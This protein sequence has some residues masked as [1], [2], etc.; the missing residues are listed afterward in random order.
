MDAAARRQ[1]TRRRDEALRRPAGRAAR[2]GACARPASARRRSS[3]ASPTPTRAGRTR[4]SRPSGSASTCASCGKLFDKYG[5]RSALYGHF[6][7]GCIHARLE[8]R[9]RHAPT[10][11]RRTARFLDEAADLV[12]VA[13]RLALRRARRRPVARRAAAEDVRR[14]AGRG[15]P[16]VQVD[17]GPGLEDEPRQGRRPGPR[18]PRTS[19]SAPTTTRRRSKTHFAYPRRRR[20]LRARDRCAAS[21]S[22]SAG[23]PSGGVMCPSYMVTREEKHS[24]R[25]RARLLWEMLNGE[26]ARAAGATRRSTRRSTSASRARAARATARSTST[27]RRYKAEFLSHYYERPAAAAARLRVRADRPGGAARVAGAGARQFRDARRRASRALAKRPRASRRSARSRAS[28]RRRFRTGSR[29]RPR[30]TPA[31]RSVILWPDTF[32]N[33]FHARSA[34]PRSRCSRTRASASTIPR[35]TSAAAGRS[36]TTGCSTSRGATSSACSTRCATTSAPATPVV[37]IEPS[38]VAVFKDELPKLMPERRGRTRLAQQTFHL[39]RVP[40]AASRLRAAAARAARRS[41]TATAT[42]SATGG[43]RAENAA[44]RGDGPRRRGARRRLLRH[45]RPLGFERDHYDVSIACGE[46]VL[47]PGGARGRPS[48]TLVVADGFSCRDADRADAHRPRALH[49]AEVLK[50]A[51]ERDEL[52]LYPEHA[53]EL[54]PAPSSHGLPKK[55]LL[56][57]GAVALATGAALAARA[58]RT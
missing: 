33:H 32:N 51:R 5:Y 19:G 21:A 7:Q 56:A 38:C 2:L 26:R 12:L 41:S 25:G 13:R 46:R 52:P 30:G 36:T 14:R 42:T 39:E 10:A 16:R 31:G 44:A 40:P 45:G 49:V 15:V 54:Q 35:A 55:S 24:T 34:S 27:C 58:N 53:P 4:P 47:L 50:L 48:D 17:L 3:P 29:A 1:A 57:A 20:Q 22:A 11:S 18:S 43:S 23:A 28:R 9:P 37:G 8:L 6:G